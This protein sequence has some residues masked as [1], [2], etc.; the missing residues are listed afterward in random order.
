MSAPAGTVLVIETNLDCPSIVSGDGIAGTVRIVPPND[1]DPIQV[2]F[3]DQIGFPINGTFPFCKTPD[4]SAT[5]QPVPFCNAISN[6]LNQHPI[7]GVPCVT[8]SVDLTNPPTLHST[9]WV[10]GSGPVREAL[11]RRLGAA[12]FARRLRPRVSGRNRKRNTGNSDD[13]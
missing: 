5:P 9:L 6:G 1:T 4:A 3:E 13:P 8:E 11:G 12:G 7:D 2:V 10:K